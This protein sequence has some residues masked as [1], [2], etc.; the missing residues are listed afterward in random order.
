MKMASGRRTV[1]IEGRPRR[2]IILKLSALLFALFLT[3]CV[4]STR[5]K[6]ALS[7]SDARKAELDKT[8]A[9]LDAAKASNQ[10]LTGDFAALKAAKEK[11][12]ADCETEKKRLGDLN[13]STSDD[14]S[15]AK[16]ELDNRQKEKDYLEREVERLKAKAGEISSEK[17]KELSNVK[18]TYEKL[19]GELKGEIAKGDIKI[20]QA[21]DRLSVNMVEKIL[22]DSGRAEI[23]P[24]GIK[25]LKRVAEILKSVNDKEIRVEGHTDN[26]PI[27]ES[28]KKRFPSNWELSTARATNVV[29]YFADA[30]VNPKLLSAAGYADNKPVASNDTPEGKAQNRRIEIVLLPLNV[31]R[32]LEELKKDEMKKK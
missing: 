20:T 17:E 2:T 25:V 27:G 31:D 18:S 13:K 15:A 5:Y 14:L 24:G 22:F 7:E 23:K 12:D 3:G 30:G 9:E 8:T 16:S 10:K 11:S 19:V 4:S 28:L 21:I 32:V 6:E 26:V 29:R 1:F